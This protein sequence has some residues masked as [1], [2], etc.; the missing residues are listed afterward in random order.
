MDPQ[1]ILE[2]GL[3]QSS[4]LIHQYASYF[5]IKAVTIEHSE[6]W[7]D[8]FRKDVDDK[9]KMCIELVDLEDVVY[10]GYKTISYR[11][12]QERLEGQ[13]FD[14]VFVDGP[15]GYMLDHFSRTQIIDVVK[16]NLCERFCIII[17]D[18][19]RLGE[20]ETVAEVF[21][22]LDE[23]GVAYEQKV[24]SGQKEH[25]LICSKDLFLLTTL[26]PF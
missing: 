26:A 13:K 8:F 2:F 22:V 6:E 24:Y 1:S 12:I 10:K 5:G 14:F 21:K 15:Y 25:M 19:D 17:D 9:Y 11:G 16:N 20:K 7:M 23:K 4:K 18:Y 3:G